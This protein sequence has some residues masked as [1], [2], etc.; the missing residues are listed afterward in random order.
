MTQHRKPDRPPERLDAVYHLLDRQILDVDDRCVAK[1]DDLEL[2]ERDGVLVVTALLTGPGALGPRLGGRTG[3]ATAAIWR[4]LHPQEHPLP[5]RIAV[6]QITGIGSA[7]HVA[8]TRADLDVDGFEHWAERKVVS[9]LPLVRGGGP[10]GRG[11]RSGEQPADPEQV[12]RTV[13]LLNRAVRDRD[14]RGIGRVSDLRLRTNLVDE[15]PRWRTSGME[16]T[17]LIVNQ[18]ALATLLGYERRHDQG[19]WLLRTLLRR[20]RPPAHGSLPWARGEVAWEE[21]HV[22]HHGERLDEF[23]L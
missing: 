2:T 19:P 7:V 17:D 22:T 8:A 4:R 5:G 3:A 14:G 12:R 21:H 1:V 18:R 9:R 15:G 16:V 23:R 20:L 10:A 6:E 13:D 11:E